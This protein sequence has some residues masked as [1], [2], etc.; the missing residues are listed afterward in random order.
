MHLF[1]DPNFPKRNLTAGALILAVSSSQLGTTAERLI[2]AANADRFDYFFLVLWVVLLFAAIKTFRVG[3]AS[4]PPDPTNQR[5][6]QPG[7]D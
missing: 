1:G 2:W 4:L 7:L 5:L 6:N 3:L